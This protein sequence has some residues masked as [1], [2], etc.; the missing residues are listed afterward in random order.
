MGTLTFILGGARSGK[1]LQAQR[2]AEQAARESGREVLY[3]ATAA[4]G[5][6]EMAGRIAR[7]RAARP[8]GW[9]T[10]EEPRRVSAAIAR[11]TE[12]TG[13]VLVDCLTLLISNLLLDLED[14]PDEE[15]ET[16]V[17]AEIEAVLAAGRACPARIILVS[18]EVG[19]GVVPPSRLGRLFRDIAGR[20]H[21]RIARQ[22]DEVYFLVA[23]LAQRLK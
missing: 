2:L 11:V 5:D 9:R 23:G 10:C 1:S 16:A 18:N 3:V 22:A 21:Q 12:G 8:A 19:Q 6:T 4:A 14:R 15:I 7:H 20:A 17:L 13:V